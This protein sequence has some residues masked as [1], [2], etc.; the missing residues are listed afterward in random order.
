VWSPVEMSGVSW[1]VTEHTINIKLGSR[2]VK[3]G[4]RRFNQEKHQEM[5]E[6]LSRLLTMGFV[7]EVQPSDW[8]ANPVLVPKRNGRRWMCVDY[9]SPNEACLN[10]PFPL[11]KS[12]R[13]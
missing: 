13:S 10:D 1:E 9:T 12:I 6:E 5:G 8:I 7:K 11:P 4:L 2:P 3:Q